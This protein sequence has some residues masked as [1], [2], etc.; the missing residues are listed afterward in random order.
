MV[1]PR[2]DFPVLTSVEVVMRGVSNK[3]ELKGL[4]RVD[5]VPQIQ[6]LIGGF[7][8]DFDPYL[9]IKKALLSWCAWDEAKL[10]GDRCANKPE[11]RC[12]FVDAFQR[13]TTFDEV[14]PGVLDYYVGPF[15]RDA[16]WCTQLMGELHFSVSYELESILQDIVCSGNLGVVRWM[17]QQVNEPESRA[18][19]VSQMIHECVWYGQL[20]MLRFLLEF[21]GRGTE[22]FSIRKN[23]VRRGIN[24]FRLVDG[25][26]DND[27]VGN[28]EYYV[29]SAAT[30]TDFGGPL[31]LGCLNAECALIDIGA[32]YAQGALRAI[33][34]YEVNRESS[35]L[36]SHAADHA[37]RADNLD[38]LLWRY[39]KGLRCTQ[40]GVD[41]AAAR[42]QLRVVR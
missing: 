23:C 1:Q 26:P 42:S 39:T 14:D 36:T 15:A 8:D 13:L 38:L 27:W 34:A 24:Q 31:Q 2:V 19:M 41:G 10:E 32:S 30:T 33:T 16:E 7:L 25:R 29:R 3:R 12:K 37:A 5:T 22:R 17:L 18:V 6:D 9:I 20:L 35:V 4:P 21:A 40:A 11:K 28:L